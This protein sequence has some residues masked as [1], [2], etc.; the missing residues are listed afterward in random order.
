MRLGLYGGTFDPVHQG[1]LLLAEQCR[2]QCRL[3]NVWLLPA[4][5]PPHK[6]N[7]DIS[8]GKFRSE[9]L[10]FATAGYPEFSVNTME[11]DREGPSYTVDTLQQLTDEDSTRELFFLIGA[12]SL[13]DLPTW[14]EPQRIAELATIVAVNRGDKPLPDLKELSNQLGSETVQRIQI[15]TMPG[16]DVS[17]T[18]IRN[19]VAAGKSIR[20]MV[21]RSVEV[22]IKEHGLYA[23]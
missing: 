14:R 8:P 6:L 12:D 13:K 3:D 18:D 4:R 5:I 20:F 2:E 11:L 1:H 22:Y 10:E 19:R 17:S 23:D 16:I 9:M 7:A 15:V 21:P